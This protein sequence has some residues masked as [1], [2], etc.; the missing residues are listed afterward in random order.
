MT[1]LETIFVS[2]GVLA[3]VALLGYAIALVMITQ[4]FISRETVC[5]SLGNRPDF[6][7]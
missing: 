4:G 6:C 7:D 5:N 2:V 3:A 1:R